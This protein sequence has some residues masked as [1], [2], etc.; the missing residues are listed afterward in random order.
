MRRSLKNW[1]FWAAVLGCLL[2]LLFRVGGYW[3]STWLSKWALLVYL[4]AGAFSVAVCRRTSFLHLPLLLYTFGELITL[5]AWPLGPYLGKLDTTVIMALQNNAFYGVLQIASCAG[6]MAWMARSHR[7]GVRGIFIGLFLIWLIECVATLCLPWKGPFS[8]PNN[9]LWF[10]NPSMGSS[11]LAC[12]LPFVWSLWISLC[13]EYRWRKA[14][15]RIPLGVSWLVTFFV[16]YRTQA[17]VPWGVLGV[18]TATALARNTWAISRKAF[19]LGLGSIGVLATAMIEA[20]QHLLG[21]EFWNQNGRFEIWE[22]GW[23]HYRHFGSAIWGLGYASTQI[24]L[25]LEQL[26]TG[27]MHGQTFLWF[28]SDWLQLAIEGGFVGMFCVFLSLGRALKQSWGHTE[29]LAS[30]LGFVTL[31]V[32]DYPLRMPIHCFVLA[33]IF[34]LTERGNSDLPESYP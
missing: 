30:L 6:L 19:F 32:M 25:P 28:H 4:M 20:G 3:S 2:V 11:L 1:E 22:M 23:K 24:F 27:H 13:H 5:S 31:G 29:Y 15:V 7:E 34:G 9:G 26:T 8:P 17:S 12:L 21:Y 16:I 14:V 33:L 18:V 10:G